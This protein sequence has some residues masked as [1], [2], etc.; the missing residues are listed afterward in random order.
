[1]A[2][3]A[4]LLVIALA[5]VLLSRA[6]VRSSILGGYGTAHRSDGLE[7]G[8]QVPEDDDVRWHWGDRKRAP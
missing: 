5:L 7:Q 1:M 6:W 4:L 2:T 3:V 8:P